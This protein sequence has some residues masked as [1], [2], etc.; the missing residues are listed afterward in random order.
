MPSSLGRH[1]TKYALIELQKMDISMTM[2]YQPPFVLVSF[3]K[4]SSQSCRYPSMYAC[5]IF[6]PAYFRKKGTS[7]KA[8]FK[9]E[10]KTLMMSHADE[11]YLVSYPRRKCGCN[12]RDKA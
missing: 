10:K 12:A 9:E 11:E 1:A 4:E 3:S 6:K 8:Y 7:K 2:T 5:I